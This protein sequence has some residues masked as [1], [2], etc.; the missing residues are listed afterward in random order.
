MKAVKINMNNT[1]N[2]KS[3]KSVLT[4][5]FVNALVTTLTSLVITLVLSVAGSIFED[6]AGYIMLIPLITGG[7]TGGFTAARI[8]KS[9]GM[10][11]ALISSV[12]VLIIM[13]II[14]FSVFNTNITYM[15]L[16][17]AL[18]SIL[19]SAFGGIK[20]VNKKEKFRV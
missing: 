2:S 14:G 3:V 19:P 11:V 5:A 1:N 6:L 15:T 12:I 9:N 18:C 7:Y 4:G 13:L 17:K 20:G 8:N 16:L 10:I